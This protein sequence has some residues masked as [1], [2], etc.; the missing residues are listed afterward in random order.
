MFVRG[1]GNTIGG[2]TS[3]DLDVISGNLLDGVEIAG[4]GAIGN[5]VEGDIVGL[6]PKG[7]APVRNA[8]R[9]GGDQRRLLQHDRR[10]GPRFPERD[11]GQR[12][13]RRRGPRREPG[14]PGRRQ[15]HPRE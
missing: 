15:H 3:G 6:D 1:S 13:Q 11:L 9:R 7:V 14:R 12:R 4:A 2:T 10:V 5:V 8:V